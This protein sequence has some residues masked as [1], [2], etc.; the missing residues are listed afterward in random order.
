MR[1]RRP[2]SSTDDED[3]DATSLVDGGDSKA[4]QLLALPPELTSNS[5]GS[6]CIQ[7]ATSIPTIFS[8]STQLLL[9]SSNG[10]SEGNNWRL[11]SRSFWACSASTLCVT[12][13]S[14]VVIVAIIHSFQ[15]RQCDTKGCIKTYM[16]PAYAPLVNFDTE[17]TRFA[18]KYKTYLY[19][20]RQYDSSSLDP[21]GVPVLFI[22]GN[23][24]SYK[25]ARSMAKEAARM[26]A[27]MV[28]RNP[29][30]EE[31]GR[32]KL[33]FFTVDFNEDITAFHG[34][35]LLDQAEYLNDAV[36]YIL[37]STRDSDL[38]DPISVIIVGHS[39]GGIVART[40]LTM[41]NYQVNSVNTI[42]TL[43]TPHA[44]PPVTFDEQIVKTYTHI[45]DYWRKSYS[46]QWAP[47]NPLFYTTLISIAGGSLD[48]VVP[49]DYANVASILPETN[50]FTVFTSSIPDVWV[51]IDHLAI[52]WCNQMM[53]VLVGSL[54][55]IVDVKRSGQTKSRSERMRIFKKWYLTGMESTAEKTLPQEKPTTLL[56]LEDI[57]NSMIPQGE[58]LAIRELG[59]SRKPRAYLMPIPATSGSTGARFTLLTDRN[60]QDAR[61]EKLKVLLCSVFSPNAGGAATEFPMNLDLSENGSGSTKLACKLAG[62]DVIRLPGSRKDSKYPFEQ[63]PPFSYLQYDFGDIFEHQFVAV[64]DM[65]TSPT[66]GWAI[67]EFSNASLTGLLVDG[68]HV[69]LAAHRHLVQDLSIPAIHSSL[70]TW[71]LSFKSQRCERKE[72]LFQP[73]IRQYLSEPHESRYFVNLK[74]AD[75]NFHGSAPFMPQPLKPKAQRGLSLQFCLGKL[76]MRYR[77]IFAAFPLMMVASVLRKQFREYNARGHFMSFNEGL[78]IMI[79]QTLPITL[80]VFSTLAAYFALVN[81]VSYSPSSSSYSEKETT[82]KLDYVKNDLLI[83]L[84]DPFFW[85]LAPLFTLVSLGVVVVVNYLAMIVLRILMG[86]YT[87][88][89]Y[90]NM[91]AGDRKKSI[92]AAFVTSTPKRR[93]MT[94]LV[95]AC[96]VAFVVPYQFAYLVACIVQVATCVRALKRA[97]DIS[98]SDRYSNQWN[99]YHYS[100]SMLILMLW[101]L[102]INL[103]VLVVWIHNLAV[104]WLTPFSSHHNLISIIPFILLVETL[105]CGKMIPRVTS[106]L[107]MVTD[108]LLAFLAL[109]SGIW[110]VT[111]AYRL[112]HLVNIFVA[113]L[114][115]VHFSKAKLRTGGSMLDFFDDDE[116]SG[117]SKQRP[118]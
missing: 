40:M 89:E 71:K 16:S 8:S 113:W 25:Q 114:V 92:G 78:D 93:V 85:F 57:S 87:V 97:Y 39:M 111:Y 104:H 83:G 46:A 65:A 69:K 18:S 95:L 22:P 74:E 91:F 24:G 58:R 64:I 72:P 34:Q 27:E 94:T 36:A 21:K 81:S 7:S 63:T 13:L 107:W 4:H 12:L 53:K 45:N 84:Q 116:D 29:A 50:G 68:L 23:A 101:I 42:I 5:D 82:T 38:P 100:H 2:S 77:T 55:D 56:T 47:H 19:R 28:Q 118:E 10:V 108:I 117:G 73:I 15:T 44:R 33:D 3:A 51:G 9:S 6:F 98:P 76:V 1:S 11:R 75:I 79:A 67:A 30:I 59:G 109:Y 90:I 35:T 66:E 20:E 14:A 105:T 49:S 112:H 32:H 37:K 86:Y 43:S 41:P 80:V 99:L 61:D 26:W 103:P 106:R 48:T 17:H 54:L 70:L 52:L 96:F 62:S 110:G 102:P 115:A 60:L 31:T 88:L